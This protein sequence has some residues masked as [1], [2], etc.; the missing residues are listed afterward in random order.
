MPTLPWQ[1]VGTDL[2]EWKDS[3]YLLIID[4]FSRYIE[5][6]KLHHTTSEDVILHMKSIF[7]RHGIPEVVMSDNGPQYSSYQFSYFAKDYGFTHL[8]SSPHF[9]QSNGEAERG[10]KTIKELL[11][12]S[13][14]PYLAL[15]TYRSTP[16][17]SGYT[18]SELLM[19][20]KLRT[21]VPILREQLEPSIPDRNHLFTK[22]KEARDCQKQ[23]FDRRH[24]A[25]TKDVLQPG[26]LVWIP[27]NKCSGTV[28][29]QWENRSY[30][31][32]TSRG[33]NLRRNR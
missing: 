16:L 3:T 31:V 11:K 17:Q 1:K 13:S 15:L 18:P 7:A 8:T 6:A 24:R 19:N 33:Q 9:P 20:R 26:D 2:F 22:E 29:Q 25:K 30:E 4:Y 10:V 23:N 12:K 21:T 27:D 5:I 28:T 14:D 32:F